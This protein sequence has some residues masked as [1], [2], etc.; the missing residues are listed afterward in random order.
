MNMTLNLFIDEEIVIREGTHGDS[1]Y[2]ISKGTME[3]FIKNTGEKSQ[4]T[5]DLEAEEARLEAEQAKESKKK[6]KKGH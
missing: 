2:F 6:K 3:V 4:K 1:M 5:I